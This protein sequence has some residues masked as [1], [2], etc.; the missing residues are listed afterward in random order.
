MSRFMKAVLVVLFLFCMAVVPLRAQAPQ[1]AKPR[2]HALVMVAKVAATPVRK[3]VTTLKKT[4]GTVLFAVESGVDVAHTGLTLADKA[5]DAIGMAGKVP[6]LDAVYAV[7]GVA[8]TDS[9][10]LDHW[11]EK[12]ETYLFGTHN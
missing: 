3:P 5:F 9:G 4:L 1:G 2:T 8:A 11:L 10:K 7:V 12:Q 6:V